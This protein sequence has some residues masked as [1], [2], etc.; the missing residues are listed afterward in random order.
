MSIYREMASTT[1]LAE[2]IRPAVLAA[3]TNGQGVDIRGF[4]SA[5]AVLAVGA[6]VASGNMTPRLEESDD[7]STFTTVAAADLEGT[8]PAALVANS[9]LSVAYKG[10][11]RYVRVATTLNSG[12]SVAVA[13]MILLGNPALA[14]AA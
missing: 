13:A 5:M 4:G 11:K 12:T 9:A 6:I 1:S 7:N 10:T 8:F 14:P 2:S 3:S